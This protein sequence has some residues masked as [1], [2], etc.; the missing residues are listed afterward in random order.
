MEPPSHG[1]FSTNWNSGEDGSNRQSIIS[2][3]AKVISVVQSAIQRA[4]RCSATPSERI[5]MMNSAPA[6]GRKVVTER[7]GQLIISLPPRR[8]T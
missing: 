7:M 5:I 2:E 1:R 3:M 6:S 8:G 4:L